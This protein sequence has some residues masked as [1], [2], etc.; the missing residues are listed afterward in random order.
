MGERPGK[1][2]RCA[3]YY[4]IVEEGITVIVACWGN[5]RLVCLVIHVTLH[6]NNGTHFRFVLMTFL[7][8]AEHLGQVACELQ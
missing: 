3:L 4:G 8:L 7:N 1:M 5:Q 6:A 2:R